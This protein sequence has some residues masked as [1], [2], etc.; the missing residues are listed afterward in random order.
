MDLQSL[1]GF[2]Y[3]ARLGNL[4]RAA[5]AVCRTQP[6]LTAQLKRL[7]EELHCQ[8]FERGSGR[9]SMILTEAGEALFSFVENF[10]KQY[11]LLLDKLQKFRDGRA[12]TIRIAASSNVLLNPVGRFAESF[13]SLVP[14]SRFRFYEKFPDESMS[15][16]QKGAVDFVFALLP[17]MEMRFQ[18][19]PVHTVH[20]LM[21]VKQ[22]HRLDREM[23][24][25][26]EIVEYPLILPVNSYRYCV[27]SLF[28]QTCSEKGMTYN[29]CCESNV[30]E[31]TVDY[32]RKGFGIG[33][34]VTSEDIS[35]RYE[36]DI[37]FR[38]LDHI[39]PPTK[40]VVCTRFNSALTEIQSLFM[41]HV[42]SYSEVGR[43]AL[44]SLLGEN[45]EK[46]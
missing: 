13:L 40:L 43:A 1:K 25:L 12:G 41:Q 10:E 22:G 2:L 8:L 27:R 29:L 6:A 16:L 15:M 39:L 20:F 46:A 31:V 42:M 45:H 9:N 34:I 44:M 37:S 21:V 33:I 18:S 23:P 28:E 5:E 11:G 32:V 14:S 35:Q 26:E 30:T 19:F 4:T 17:A 24:A 36:N 7:E 38:G 3:A